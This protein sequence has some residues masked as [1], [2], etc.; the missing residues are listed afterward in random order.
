MDFS[1]Q[2][3][4]ETVNKHL[5]NQ[6]RRLVIQK[7]E[8]EGES[9]SK[10]AADLRIKRTTVNAI[11]K[12]YRSTGRSD[13]S[14][15]RGC[16]KRKISDEEGAFIEACVEFNPG[17]TLAEIKDKCVNERGLSVS[18]STIWSFLKTLAITLK[19][20]GV[21]LDRVNDQERLELRRI[22]A[23]NFLTS[24]S[25]EDR[26]NVFIDESGFNLHM[27]RNYGRSKKGTRVRFV[28]PTVRGRNLTLLSAISG[29]GIVHYK[30]FIGGCKS[31]QFSAFL[32]ELD[33]KLVQDG[34]SDGCI[35]MDN[36][37]AHKSGESRAAMGELTNN[38]AYM[39][40]YS[41][42]LNPI[43]FC[44]SKIKSI[45]RSLLGISDVDLCVLTSSAISR[46]TREDCEGW[47]RLIRRNCALA[48][49][50]HRFE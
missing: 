8:C 10:V 15:S 11:L 16:P 1:Q 49:Q 21:L 20:S 39:S 40:P 46:I 50:N 7:V 28:V 2:D 26:K 44:F 30:L 34:I 32:K 48:I 33:E 6:L 3:D 14:T 24:A 17:I 42:M 45:V 36:A 25:M 12:V 41:Y 13:A 18:L 19:R 43:E 29:V 47:Y 4:N 23:N 9:V 22:F 38:C 31:E 27:R 35:Y 37:S 5:T